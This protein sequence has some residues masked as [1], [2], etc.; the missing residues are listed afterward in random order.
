MHRRRWICSSSLRGRSELTV[1]YKILYWQEI[2]VQISVESDEDE[3]SVPLPPRFMERVDA[4]AVQRG[5]QGGDDYLNQWK[6]SETQE[7]EGESAAAVAQAIKQDLEAR[8][9]W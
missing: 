9:N 1:A 2:P 4:L 7:R 6:W 3:L 8:A 5:L